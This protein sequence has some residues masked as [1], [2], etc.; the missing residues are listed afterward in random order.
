MSKKNTIPMRADPEFKSIINRVTAKNLMKNNTIKTPRITLAIAR[1]YKK[2]P[3]LL[4]E[5]EEADLK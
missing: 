2:Y 1:Q 3:D 5:L 4:K